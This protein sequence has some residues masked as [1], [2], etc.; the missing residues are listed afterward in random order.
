MDPV[1]WIVDGASWRTVTT[2][3][4]L[5]EVEV[6]QILQMIKENLPFKKKKNHY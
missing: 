1:E 3:C 6:V 4:L 5:M 2:Q